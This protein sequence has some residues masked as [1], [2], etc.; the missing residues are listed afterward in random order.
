MPI[1]I[2]L[3]LMISLI[4]GFF[5]TPKASALYVKSSDQATSNRVSVADS[6]SLTFTP[7]E[8]GAFSLTSTGNVYSGDSSSTVVST[9]GTSTRVN[10]FWINKD[11]LLGCKGEDLAVQVFELKSGYGLTSLE[12]ELSSADGDLEG[13]IVNKFNELV[14]SGNIIAPA[15]NRTA[16]HA[17]MVCRYFD[18]NASMLGGSDFLYSVFDIS[19]AS[20]PSNGGGPTPGSGQETPNSESWVDSTGADVTAFPASRFKFISPIELLDSNTNTY[21]IAS[22]YP[23]MQGG[24]DDDN[25]LFADGAVWLRPTQSD[26]KTIREKTTDGKCLGIVAVTY[27]SGSDD[28]KYGK[29]HFLPPI[30]NTQNTCTIDGA[31]INSLTGF[32]ETTDTIWSFLSNQDNQDKYDKTQEFGSSEIAPALASHFWEN[33]D[34]IKTIGRDVSLKKLGVANPRYSVLMSKLSLE[35]NQT[36]Y[37]FWTT[38]ACTANKNA[39]DAFTVLYFKKETSGS[40]SASQTTAFNYNFAR[41]LMARNV[42]TSDNE[43][44]SKEFDATWDSDEGEYIS[45]LLGVN[46]DK[47]PLIQATHQSLYSNK[48]LLP[49]AYVKF[50]TMTSAEVAA[51]GGL[52]STLTGSQDDETAG[53]QECED[54]FNSFG[55]II[56]YML[57]FVDGTL[58][59]FESVIKNLLEVSPS[60][61][62]AVSTVDGEERSPLYLAWNSL[63]RLSSGL[64]VMIALIM[65]ISTALGDYKL[66]NAYTVKK[67]LPRLVIAAIG[68]WLSWAIV[69]TYIGAI[70]TIGKGIADLLWTPFKDT[71]GLTFEQYGLD[72]AFGS[73]ARDTGGATEAVAGTAFGFTL[74]GGVVAAGAV[75]L[76]GGMAIISALAPILLFM[77]IG[78]IVLVLR[79]SI[80]IFLLA[81][82]PIAIVSWVLP[83]TQKLI[84]DKWLK[85]LNQ[86]LFMFPMF[87]GVLAA[88]KIFAYV[89]NSGDGGLLSLIIPVLAYVTPFVLLPGIFKSAGGALSKVT[90]ALNKQGGKLSGAALKPLDERVKARK[91]AINQERRVQSLQRLGAGE[92]G[93]RDRWR[94]GATGP[95]MIPGR[96]RR[97]NYNKAQERILDSAKDEF[98]KEE[99]RLVNKEYESLQRTPGIYNDAN[100]LK[101]IALDDPGSHRSR[102]A[103][104]RIAQLG[105]DDSARTIRE[106]LNNSSA[107]NESTRAAWQKW[108]NSSEY[109]SG[110]KDKAPD[111]IK[112]S[113]V[114]K[115]QT[116]ESVKGWTKNTWKAAIEQCT[117]VSQMQHYVN[118]L[119]TS[120]AAGDSISPEKLAFINDAIAARSA[121]LGTSGVTIDS[122]HLARTARS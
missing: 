106:Q 30:K 75:A 78:F 7:E 118:L 6:G 95:G 65:V 121:S 79:Q 29:T 70:N 97:S 15:D 91:N 119:T 76:G 61:Y 80:I 101:T 52:P 117:D 53:P 74:I 115:T 41:F 67:V 83:N 94:L 73:A 99:E 98:K 28:G 17:F 21:Y 87:M 122:S 25:S 5:G 18:G 33:K 86:L 45:C 44:N 49:M 82:A 85:F 81:T 120:A 109:Y 84:W 58:G 93:L 55:V 23:R 4:S 100:A 36:N 2:V 22:G 34:S 8:G 116:G 46:V 9:D 54:A 60:S 16:T 77:F 1:F 42:S 64:L 39:T 48:R 72:D 112:G 88:G 105:D 37:E 12:N 38:D 104:Q 69:S 3:A 47:S 102:A 66:F 110:F 90:G 63:A 62:S 113:I 13:G 107:A 108:S 27:I 57:K 50:A 31:P 26:K 92:A 40:S 35:E 68:I 10:A 103:L 24:S 111:L 51:D 19:N 56:C 11:L 43:F 20:A 96:N 89:S 59:M 71:T 32:V 14:T 114:A